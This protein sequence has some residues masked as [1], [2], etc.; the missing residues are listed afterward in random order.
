M[1]IKSIDHIAPPILHVVM[2]VV[3]K[4]Y[5]ILVKE[6]EVLDGENDVDEGDV[7]S[8]DEIQEE[9]L[10]VQETARET[11]SILEDYGNEIIE[12]HNRKARH[13]A[14]MNGDTKEN[15]NLARLSSTNKTIAVNEQCKTARCIVTNYDFNVEWLQCDRCDAWCHSVCEGLTVTEERS[16]AETS[17]EFECNQCK[18]ADINAIPEVLSAKIDVLVIEQSSCKETLVEIEIEENRLSDTIS[19]R[20][21]AHVTKLET[22]LESIG[23]ERG[24]YHGGS[25]N[26]NMA[27]KLLQNF[28][29][30]LEAVVEHDE[31]LHKFEIIF[32]ILSRLLPLI[33]TTRFLSPEEIN[34]V[35]KSCEE[36]GEAYPVL[37]HG[38]TI[39]TH[40]IPRFVKKWKSVGLFAEQA[41]ESVHN[42]FNQEGRTLACVKKKKF[43]LMLLMQAQ[44]RRCRADMTSSWKEERICFECRPAKIFKKNVNGTLVCPNC[45]T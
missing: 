44:E 3:E 43:K 23:V 12:I 29:I 24:T 17:D 20:R 36:F 4:L 26:G 34:E 42:A 11:K 13:E 30:L 25:F 35:C 9:L 6:C 45:S 19:K 33:Y 32:S 2:G 37:F 28:A 14:M 5:Q 8:N 21:G 40:K 31:I 22:A 18:G 38:E 15:E 1:P 39:I 7:E 16:L 27:T 10:N 41:G